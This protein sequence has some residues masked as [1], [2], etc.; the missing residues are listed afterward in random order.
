LPDLGAIVHGIDLHNLDEA[1]FQ[2]LREHLYLYN[3]IC[4]KGQQ[5]LSPKSQAELTRMFDPAAKSYGHG[6]TLDAKRSILHPDLKTVPDQPEVQVIGNGHI[7]SYE[8]LENIKLKHPHHRSFHRTTIPDNMDLDYTRFYRW[9]IDAAL[10]G[11][12]QPPK[13]TSLLAIKV[14]GGRK[15]TLVYDDGTVDKLEVPLGTTAFVSGYKMFELLSPEQ[16]QLAMPSKIEY[17]PH[18]YIWIS[19]AKSRSDGLGM[20]S[21]GL[22]ISSS[23]LSPSKPSDIQVH[24]ML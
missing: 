19:S 22:E 17:A 3:V 12:L 11:E 4:V 18:P 16:K 8:G 1:D 7:A 10:F 21:E 2:R 5:S 15:E 9:Y 20:V 24:P 14:P 23:E 13:V 6:R